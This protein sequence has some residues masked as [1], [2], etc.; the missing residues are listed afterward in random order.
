MKKNI[1]KPNIAKEVVE[2]NSDD[3]AKFHKRATHKTDKDF[4]KYDPLLQGPVK[5]YPPSPY[6]LTRMFNPLACYELDETL[7]KDNFTVFNLREIYSWIVNAK[8]SLSGFKFSTKDYKN[9]NV[10]KINKTQVKRTIQPLK[11]SILPRTKRHL[12]EKDKISELAQDKLTITRLL[13]LLQANLQKELIPFI[14]LYAEEHSL[15]EHFTNPTDLELTTIDLIRDDLQAILDDENAQ[16]IPILRFYPDTGI[17]MPVSNSSTDLYE[18]YVKPELACEYGFSKNSSN[19]FING[20]LKILSIRENM[21]DSISIRMEAPQKIK[22][23]LNVDELCL[24]ILSLTEEGLLNSDLRKSKKINH[25]ALA[26]LIKIHFSSIGQDDLSVRSI[27]NKFYVHDD[28]YTDNIIKLSNVIHR[29][30]GKSH[31]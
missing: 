29:I 23:N 4:L 8:D 28:F 5:V 9:K 14:K 6:D 1:I 13:S 24:L 11:T 3:L 26:R 25:R 16:L 31:I 15:H 20:I 21:L 30:K 17:I 2:H 19:G 7:D 18:L 22:F 12:L 27:L 10:L